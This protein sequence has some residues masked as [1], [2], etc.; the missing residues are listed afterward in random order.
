M[1]DLSDPMTLVRTDLVE[2][3]RKVYAE[4]H[5]R[6]DAAKAVAGRALEAFTEAQARR[7]ELVRAAAA[8]QDV[9]VKARLAAETAL[10]ETEA[11]YTFARDAAALTEAGV[12]EAARA[13]QEAERLAWRPVFLR[14]VL[15]RLAAMDDIAQ[16]KAA[17]AK[18]ERDHRAG[19]DVL[20]AAMVGQAYFGVLRGP[21]DF[22]WDKQRPEAQEF[23]FWRQVSIPA[24]DL[25]GV[26]RELNEHRMALQPTALE[27]E[28]LADA[29]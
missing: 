1:F 23:A 14:G 22:D 21:F 19:T 7:S 3:A 9:A 10:K 12:P 2:T 18:A 4:A 29:A 24:E 15:M 11:N 6:L 25:E 16:A 5:A 27:A 8:G 17:L 28:E 13:I 20:N 26:R